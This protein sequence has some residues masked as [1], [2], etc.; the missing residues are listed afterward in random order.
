MF[1]LEIHASEARMYSFCKYLG[2][3]YEHVGIPSTGQAGGLMVCWK[4]SPYISCSLG[5]DQAIYLVFHPPNRDPSLFV[6]V[7]A[8]T[9]VEARKQMWDETTEV[10]KTGLPT[11]IA[12]DFNTLLWSSDKRGGAPFR[13]TQEVL[14]FRQWKDMNGLCPLVAKGPKFTWCNNRQGSARTWELLDRAF[15]N[16]EWLTAFPSAVVEVLPRSYS[17]HAPCC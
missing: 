14:S 13:V 17:D 3:E 4:N 6:G 11:V 7:Y 5:T 16:K 15:A 10:I 2:S 1:L 9:Q 8:S 12:G